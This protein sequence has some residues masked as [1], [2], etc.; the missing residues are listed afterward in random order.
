M[1]YARRAKAVARP[2]IVVREVNV[3][4]GE[5]NYA[6]L[7]PGSSGHLATTLFSDFAG[8]RSKISKRAY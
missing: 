3:C 8:A 6:S 5:L 1:M 2:A 7:G 4:L